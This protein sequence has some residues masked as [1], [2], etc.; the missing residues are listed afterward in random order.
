[1]GCNKAAT[2]IIAGH[3]LDYVVRPKGARTPNL[4]IGRKVDVAV[5]PTRRIFPYREESGLPVGT[6]KGF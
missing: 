2:G 1:M 6:H 4:L 5:I 3:G